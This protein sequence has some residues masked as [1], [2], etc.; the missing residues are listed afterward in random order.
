MIRLRGVTKIYGRKPVLDRLDLD[1]PAGT[2][3]G[4]LAKN[5]AGKTTLI[6][7]A[8]GLVRPQ[9][10]EIT[11]LGEPAWDLSAAA[12]A[13]L[14]YVPQVVQLH[15]WMKVRQVIAYIASFYP[16]WNGPL[17]ERLVRDWELPPEDR[18]GPLSVGQLQKLAILLALGHEPELLLLDE[19]A[20]SLDPSARRQF[21]RT[22]LDIA[23]DARRTVVFS[24]HI[25]SDLERVADH[26]AILKEGRILYHGPLDELKDRHKRL[27]VNAAEPLPARLDLPGVIRRRVEGNEAVLTVRDFDSSTLDALRTRWRASVEVEDLNL[28]D[29]FLELHDEA[30]VSQPARHA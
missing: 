28:E 22:V 30:D 6:K 3:L 5:G 20:A 25:T 9:V 23:A 29:I 8:L 10:G 17:V 12:K 19:P 18:V 2:V 7:A 27:H 1:V 4:L 15:P 11:L 26:V 16:R 13:R 14:G 21:L 24:T